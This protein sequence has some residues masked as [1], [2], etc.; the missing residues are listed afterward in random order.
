MA[1][2]RSHDRG[3]DAARTETLRLL[4]E[5]RQDL[6]DLAAFVA[7]EEASVDRKAFGPK[8]VARLRL[9]AQDVASA[10]AFARRSDKS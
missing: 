6:D 2:A 5:I 4:T 3:S 1:K 8:R 9:I 10:S 7:A